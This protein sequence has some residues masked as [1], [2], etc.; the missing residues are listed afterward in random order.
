MKEK[1]LVSIIIPAYNAEK[2]LG[3]ALDSVLKQTYADWEAIVVDDGS[4]DGTAEIAKNYSLKDRRIKYVY[5][6]N[7]RMAAA[8]NKGI[9]IAKGEYVAFLDADNI[10]W[11]N[12]LE[13][14]VW[15]LESHP[16]CGISYARI[17]HFYNGRP[18]VLYENKNEE[19][20]RG[21][22]LRSLLWRNSINVL[23]VLIRKE[24]D[25]KSVV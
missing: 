15:F 8:R 17:R 23:S 3:E 11:P 7:R 14:Q 5:Q 12:K 10:F 2:F 13:A 4:T 24:L 1:N 25:R 19:P 16:N 21:D 22:A 20:I 6:E 9:S 18:G